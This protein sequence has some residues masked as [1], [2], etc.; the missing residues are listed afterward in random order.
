MQAHRA[1]A[2]VDARDHRDGHRGRHHHLSQRCRRPRQHIQGDRHHL[3]QCLQLAAPAG[4]DH[5]VADDPEPQQGHGD[6]PGEDDRGHPPGKLTQ[7]GKRHQRGAGECLV[8]DRVRDLA[9]VS[10]QAAAA[11]EPAIQQ[12]RHGGH[13]EHH[14][15]RHPPVRPASQQARDED[16]YQNQSQHRQRVRDVDQPG[17]GQ[18]GHFGLGR[19]LGLGGQFGLGC[20]RC[21]LSGRCE[22]GGRGP[23]RPCRT[24]GRLTSRQHQPA[25]SARLARPRRGG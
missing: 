23:G 25:Q 10:D 17:P 19:Q 14:E 13:A 5:S 21:R 2:V 6:L 16:R 22:P 18:S 3:Q 12:I 20:G 9:K 24:L 4:S 11:G 15:R 1:N 8:R 7:G